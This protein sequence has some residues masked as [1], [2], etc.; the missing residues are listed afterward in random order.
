MQTKTFTAKSVEAVQA[1]TAKWLLK[2]KPEK[3]FKNLKVKANF[4]NQEKTM[5]VSFDD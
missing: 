2:N 4:R 3:G 5:K 1:K